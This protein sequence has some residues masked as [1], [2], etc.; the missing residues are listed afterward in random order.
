MRNEAILSGKKLRHLRAHTLGWRGEKLR[1]DSFLN[2]ANTQGHKTPLFWCFQ[3]YEEMASL[4]EHLGADQPL[5]GMRSAKHVMPHS[6]ENSLALATIYLAEVLELQ[7][8]EPFRLG[9]NCAG[10]R[11]ILPLAK[12]LQDRGKQVELVCTLERFVPQ[13]YSGRVTMLFGQDSEL[14]PYRKM[15]APEELYRKHYTGPLVVRIVPG[16]HGQFFKPP[17]IKALANTITEELNGQQ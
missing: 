4:A 17:N 8:E 10:A 12:M 13:N 11:I 15:D 1:P 7:Q 6:E 2:G 16:G 3:S 14:N 5:Y 9:A